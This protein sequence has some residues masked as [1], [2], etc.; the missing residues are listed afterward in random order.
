MYNQRSKE[1]DPT[2]YVPGLPVYVDC[3]EG[4]IA[5]FSKIAGFFKNLTYGLIGK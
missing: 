3:A 4:I 1:F 2:L 5:I